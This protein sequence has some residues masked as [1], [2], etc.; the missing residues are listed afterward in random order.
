MHVHLAV[1]DFFQ[2]TRT[3]ATTTTTTTTTTIQY[4]RSVSCVFIK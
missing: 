4:V 3:H 1:T 2:P